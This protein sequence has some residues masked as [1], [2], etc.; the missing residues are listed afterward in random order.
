MMKVQGLSTSRRP[1]LAGTF[2]RSFGPVFNGY[3]ESRAYISADIYARC[4]A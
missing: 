1:M 2:D 4:P 3:V